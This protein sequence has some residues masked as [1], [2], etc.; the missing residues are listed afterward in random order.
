MEICLW[1]WCREY[2]VSS[3]RA[4]NAHEQLILGGYVADN[5]AA[6][7]TALALNRDALLTLARNSFLASFLEEER[8]RTYLD[9][10]DRFAAQPS[11]KTIS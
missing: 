7:A 1:L 3:V 4:T 5:F 6:C 10:V 2:L 9:D 8:R 11:L